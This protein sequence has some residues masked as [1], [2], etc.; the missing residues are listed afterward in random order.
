MADFPQSP[1]HRFTWLFLAV[2][3]SNPD[4]KPHRV[5]IAAPDEQTAREL[6]V[7]HYAFYFAG[8]VPVT[9][10]AVQ[11]QPVKSIL[12]RVRAIS[13][14]TQACLDPILSE[15]YRERREPL[16]RFKEALNIAGIAYA[17]GADHE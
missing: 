14:E 4:E 13:E 16:M 2:S 1:E 6:L 15:V 10:D 9:L 7:S 17:E 11:S 5:S 8:R 3:R 12:P